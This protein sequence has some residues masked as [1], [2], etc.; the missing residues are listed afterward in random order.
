MIDIAASY[1]GIGF[2]IWLV[3]FF[4]GLVKAAKHP[5]PHATLKIQ[6]IGTIAF[7]IFWPLYVLAALIGAAS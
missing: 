4:A 7:L 1:F 6:P 5:S 3:T 2:A